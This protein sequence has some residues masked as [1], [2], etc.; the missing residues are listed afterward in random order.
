MTI[1]HTG[2]TNRLYTRISGSV[3]H[4]FNIFSSYVQSKHTVGEYLCYFPWI[5]ERAGEPF[6]Q[7]LFCT[8]VHHSK[9]QTTELQKRQTSQWQPDGSTAKWSPGG[10]VHKHHSSG[11]LTP[12]MLPKWKRCG[13]CVSPLEAINGNRN[14]AVVKT[15]PKTHL[16][17]GNR[18]F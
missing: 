14:E 2:G 12:H 7:L 15:D 11:H 5:I 9:R 18:H 13:F 6:L 3:T 16:C 8:N 10:A 4:L 17:C 1:A